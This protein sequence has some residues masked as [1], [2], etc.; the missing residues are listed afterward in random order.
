MNTKNK[1]EI[2]SENKVDTPENLGPRFMDIVTGFLAICVIVIM[3]VTVII[4][5]IMSY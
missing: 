5:S 4:P 2:V 1:N 3:V